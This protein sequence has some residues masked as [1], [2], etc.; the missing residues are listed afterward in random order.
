MISWNVGNCS[1][2]SLGC[3]KCCQHWEQLYGQLLD[4][5]GCFTRISQKLLLIRC[6]CLV[7]AQRL[8]HDMALNIKGVIKHQSL[9][10][11]HSQ[12]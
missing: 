4:S 2:N 7:F 6:L 10:W 1:E 3:L 9:G 11:G 12:K 5:L 8:M